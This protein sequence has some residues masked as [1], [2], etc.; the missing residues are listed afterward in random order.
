MENQYHMHFI[1]FIFKWSFK[2]DQ[3]SMKTSQHRAVSHQN[4]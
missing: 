3:L 1:S 2:E 4:F